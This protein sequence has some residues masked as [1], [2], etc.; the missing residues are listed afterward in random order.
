MKGILLEIA[1]FTGRFTVSIVLWAYAGLVLFTWHLARQT[2]DWAVLLRVAASVLNDLVW[3]PLGVIVWSA[4]FISVVS[5]LRKRKAFLH[6]VPVAVATAAIHIV[7]LD[8][9][10]KLLFIPLMVT[11]AS[12]VWRAMYRREML[13]PLGWLVPLMLVTALTF[14]H[15][16]SQ[17][18]PAFHGTAS[19]DGITIMSYNIFCNGGSE[20]RKMVIDTIRREQPDVVCCVEFNFSSDLELLD[21]ELLKLYP[22]SL[23]N[24]V[25]ETSRRRG[26]DLLHVP[27][28]GDNYPP[29][30]NRKGRKRVG[31]WIS[32]YSRR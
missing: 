1:R 11:G 23:A 24:D 17:M 30:R 13:P 2:P 32:V 15:Y 9:A 31:G 29:A 10:F 7:F 25:F 6:V 16:R 21:R 22:Y 8:T 19:R 18:I 5:A 3:V 12:L 20:D 26:D 27:P 4:V 14:F 28:F